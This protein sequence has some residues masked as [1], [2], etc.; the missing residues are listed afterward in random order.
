MQTVLYL[1]GFLSGP[2]SKKACMLRELCEEKGARYVAPDINLSPLEASE[3]I[4][5]EYEAAR[6]FGEVAVAGAS[7]GGFYAAWLAARTGIRAVLLNP[8]VE[9]WDI[10][11]HYNG[12]YKSFTGER[13]V[14]VT[15]DYA[16]ELRELDAAAFADPSRVLMLLCTGDEVLDWRRAAHRFADVQS[17]VIEGSDHRISCFGDYAAGVRDFLLG[18]HLRK[19]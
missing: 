18:S 5:S 17:I 8:A 7:L 11:K 2:G 10:V 3:L 1:H 15:A 6:A 12:E 14:R 9:P 19:N 13:T 16:D 4:V